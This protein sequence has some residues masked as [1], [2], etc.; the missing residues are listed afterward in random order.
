[1]PIDPAVLLRELQ[2]DPLH[3][4]LV[5]TDPTTQAHLLNAPG[6][7]VLPRPTVAASEAAACIVRAEWM[8][9]PPSDQLYL[10]ALLGAGPSISTEHPQVRANLQ[11]I[12]PPGSKTIAALVTLAMRPASR[13]ETL[14]GGGTR[15]DAS[16]IL[17]ALGQ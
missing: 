3:L 17:R 11:A 12:F 10:L 7:E 13:G 6:S 2:T 14:F 16:D 15:F 5:G 8:E 4:G 1:M 9:L